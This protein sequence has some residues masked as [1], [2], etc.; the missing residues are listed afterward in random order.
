MVMFSFLTEPPQ[1]GARFI[2]TLYVRYVLNRSFTSCW[3]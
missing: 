1:A 2:E 3:I